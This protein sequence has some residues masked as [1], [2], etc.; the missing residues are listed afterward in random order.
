[1]FKILIV[2]DDDDVSSTLRQWLESENH[3]VDVATDGEE[4]LEFIMRF[5]YD[6]LILDWNLPR[7]T[8]VEICRRYR[9][10]GGNARI[11]MLTGRETLSEKEYGLDAGA[12]DYMTKPFHPREVLARIRAISRR[13]GTIAGKQLTMGSL[14]LDVEGKVVQKDGKAVHLPPAEFRLL[15]FFLRNKEQVFSVEALSQRLWKSDGDTS[16]DSVYAC[17]KRLRKLIDTK[18]EKS[19]I[20][21]VHGV[22]YGMRETED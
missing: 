11:I 17:I 12:D 21:T 6:F 2:E 1:M 5:E 22:G 4:G 18:G 15:E 19:Y 7:L 8:G 20:R 10:K 13:P 9:Q 14:S 3:M 16:L